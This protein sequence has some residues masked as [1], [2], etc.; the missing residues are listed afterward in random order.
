VLDTPTAGIRGDTSGC[1]QHC[2]NKKVP[3]ESLQ[4][5]FL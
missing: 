2:C 3:E 5:F 1:E 4:A